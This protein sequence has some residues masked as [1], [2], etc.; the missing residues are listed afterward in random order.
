MS[1]IW[2]YPLHTPNGEIQMPKGAQIL[3]VGDQGGQ[4]TLWAKVDPHAETG[5]LRVS[6]LGTGHEIPLDAGEHLG[7]VQQ[8]PYVWHIFGLWIR[9]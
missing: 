5:W 6:I 2:K 3:H 1:T 4:I 8:P 7:T 9:K